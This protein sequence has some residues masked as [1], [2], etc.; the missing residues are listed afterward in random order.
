MRL[1][2]T[3]IAVLVTV[4]SMRAIIFVLSL[5]LMACSAAEYENN[6]SM[7][8]MNFVIDQDA[9]AK[10]N[11][12][13]KSSMVNRGELLKFLPWNTPF[14]TAVNGR[15]LKV[16]ELMDDGNEKSVA[17]QGRMVKRQAPVASDYLEVSSGSTL[18]HQ[19]D[20]TKSYNF[21][22]NRRYNVS[23]HGDFLNADF[24]TVEVAL[25]GATFRTES[26]FPVCEDSES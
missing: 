13:L 5:T 3:I 12:L 24:E 14:D 15:F 16:V 22:R 7:V 19:L 9:L 2:Y 1:R 11:V 8:E 4:T 23:L 18:N 6:S 26:N 17:Y 10:G 21:C 25:S 20:I